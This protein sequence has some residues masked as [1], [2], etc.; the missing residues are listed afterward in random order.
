[1]LDS[2]PQKVPCERDIYNIFRENRMSPNFTDLTKF[3]EPVGSLLYS[4]VTRLDLSFI[5]YGL[6]QDIA[7]PKQMF[8]GTRTYCPTIPQGHNVIVTTVQ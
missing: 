1:M 7:L 8:L 6:V 4:Q 2:R 5:M 3:D